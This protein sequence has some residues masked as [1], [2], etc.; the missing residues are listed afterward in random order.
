MHSYSNKRINVLTITLILALGLL[1]GCAGTGPGASGEGSSGPKLPWSSGG[2]K[3]GY[4]RSD[5]VM[6]RYP[7]Y[8]DVENTLRAENRKWINDAENMEQAILRK[9][10]ELEELSL[11]L[12]EERKNQLIEEI[13]K[14]RQALHKF[15]HDTWYAENSEYMKRRRELM[16]PIDAMVNDAIWRVAEDQGLDLVFDTIAGNIVYV[17]PGNDITDLVLEEL[18]R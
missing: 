14:E 16:E 10:A 9:E 15:R 18:Q 2:L 4:I 5:V 13:A 12:S 3:I 6:Q 1:A 11:I 8:R 17:K 7:D